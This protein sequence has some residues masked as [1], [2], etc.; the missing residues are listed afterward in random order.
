MRLRHLEPWVAQWALP[1]MHVGVPEM[2]AVDAWHE[3]LTILEDLKLNGKSFVGGVADIAKFFDQ[4]RREMVYRVAR[5]AGM[6]EQIARAYSS[7]FENL[8]IYNNLAG[9]L[10][11]PLHEKV[12]HTTGM[13]VLHGHGCSYH[14][15][16]GA[17]NAHLWRHRMLYLSR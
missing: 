16:M 9:G 7:Y 15:T 14:E 17:D 10:G 4:I 1:E 13:P 8:R 3:V 5:A 6:P 2:G 12:W 11:P